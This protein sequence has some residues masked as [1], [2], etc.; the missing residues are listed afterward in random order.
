MSQEINFQGLP[1]HQ[2]QLDD[3]I[4]DQI[5][6]KRDDLVEVP[7]REILVSVNTDFKLK[8]TVE[9][10][11]SGRAFLESVITGKTEEGNEIFSIQISLIAIFN[12]LAPV[13]Q[14]FFQ[15]FMQKNAVILLLPKIRETIYSLCSMM[16]LPAVRLPLINVEHT[17]TYLGHL[18]ET[19]K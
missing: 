4:I 16:E 9:N 6:A 5:S 14:K 17:K 15:E 11:T 10:E 8:V 12:S 13:E 1:I 2:I 18:F 19:E 3:I 7:E